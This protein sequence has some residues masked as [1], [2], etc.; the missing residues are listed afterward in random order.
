MIVVDGT[1]KVFDEPNTSYYSSLVSYDSTNKQYLIQLGTTQP[2]PNSPAAVSVIMTPQEIELMTSTNHIKEAYE[3]AVN[4][5]N[6][7]TPICVQTVM[8]APGNYNEVHVLNC[9]AEAYLKYGEQVISEEVPDYSVDGRVISTSTIGTGIFWLPSKLASTLTYEE[10]IEK[11]GGRQYLL[12]LL[13]DHNIHKQGL[14]RME[15]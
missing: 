7:Y 10:V 1:Q 12:K 6:G 8:D 9:D 4:V 13:S 11:L 5:G 15:K 3:Y 14:P 2:K